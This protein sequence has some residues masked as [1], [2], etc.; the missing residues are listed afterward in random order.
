M[1]PFIVPGD[2]GWLDCANDQEA[3][4]WWDEHLFHLNERN[5]TEWASDFSST[6]N[7]W[8]AMRSTYRPQFFSF[9][10]E[11]VLFIGFGLPGPQNVGEW[12]KYSQQRMELEQDN[13]EW[14]HKNIQEYDESFDAVVLLTHNADYF[15]FFM[16]AVSGVAKHKAFQKRPVLILE[17]AHSFQIANNVNGLANVMRIRT[18]DTVTPMSITVDPSQKNIE[19]IFQYDRRCPCSTLHNPTHLFKYGDDEECSS[20]CT[21]AYVAC[22]GSDRCKPGSSRSHCLSVLDRIRWSR[23]YE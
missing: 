15:H 8:D 21:D 2:N 5:D 9:I 4:G 3:F 18:D 13:I 1:Q 6:V 12:G 11:T 22:H 14:L 7:R 23:N 16:N 10:I 20:E 17:D 19:D